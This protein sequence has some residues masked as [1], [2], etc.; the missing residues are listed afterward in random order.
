MTYDGNKL[1]GTSHK[2]V[3]FPPI[4]PAITTS[5]LTGCE[6]WPFGALLDLDSRLQKRWILGAVIAGV[7]RHQLEVT[8]VLHV[9]CALA[10]ALQVQVHGAGKY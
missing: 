1:V 5:A 8:P 2:A 3:L 10:V 9:S 6:K 7:K 4:E